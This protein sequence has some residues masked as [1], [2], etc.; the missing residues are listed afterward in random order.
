MSELAAA[1]LLERLIRDSY[2]PRR[3]SDIQPLQWA[4]LRHLERCGAE[5]TNLSAVT[6]GVGLTLS[7]V[8]RAVSTLADRGLVKRVSN[9]ENAREVL[10]TLTPLGHETGQNQGRL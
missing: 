4:I 1:V 8:S 3:S 10:V 5:R 6:Q 7:P 9:P 2:G